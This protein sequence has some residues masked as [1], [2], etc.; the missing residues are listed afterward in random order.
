MRR[1]NVTAPQR[2]DARPKQ[3]PARHAHCIV[4]PFF[5]AREKGTH[6]RPFSFP[7][8]LTY[9][10][11]HRWRLIFPNFNYKSEISLK[12]I[13]SAMSQCINFNNYFNKIYKSKIRL[14]FGW[15]LTFYRYDLY[16]T[17]G[18]SWNQQRWLPG[19]QK[20]WGAVQLQQFERVGFS[21]P[22]GGVF[23]NNTIWRAESWRRLT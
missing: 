1:W 2:A 14:F 21:S 16:Q 5:P 22:L 20:C 3:H 8:H 12:K 15:A 17:V 4:R 19:R 13:E 6:R 18:E 9:N 23:S 7:Y 11:V 10:F